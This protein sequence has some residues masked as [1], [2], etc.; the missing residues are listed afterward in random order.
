MVDELHSQKIEEQMAKTRG[1]IYASIIHDING[2]LTVISGFVQ[3]MGQ[4]IGGA[5]QPRTG[6]PGF[7]QGPARRPSPAR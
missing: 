1:E 6:G 5:T 2:P 7:H 3:L 4:R